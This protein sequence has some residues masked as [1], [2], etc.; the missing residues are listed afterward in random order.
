MKHIFQLFEQHTSGRNCLNCAF[1]CGLDN[2]GTHQ[3]LTE[4]QRAPANTSDFS[5]LDETF[6]FGGDAVCFHEQWKAKKVENLRDTIETVIDRSIRDKTSRYSDVH[7]TN[8]EWLDV[9]SYW[10]RFHAPFDPASS[11]PVDRIWREHQQAIQETKD[12]RRFW[13]TTVI[14]TITATAVSISAILAWLE[15]GGAP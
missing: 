2:A 3:S 6:W 7:Q 11:K 14:L 5:R 10:C 1:L 8:D 9:K 13:I 12:R 15:W 4:T